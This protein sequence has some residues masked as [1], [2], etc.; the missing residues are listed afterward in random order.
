MDEVAAIEAAA[1]EPLPSTCSGQSGGGGRGGGTL[2]SVCGEADGASAQDGCCGVCR[3][4]DESADGVRLRVS[5]PPVLAFRCGFC[6]ELVEV[7]TRSDV[8]VVT[9]RSE[10][11]ARACCSSSD[12]AMFLF[13]Y[14]RAFGDML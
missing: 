13:S 7:R 14:R 12:W 6:D 8:C 2:R 10:S 5:N 1:V 4:I 9:T 11:A 3:S